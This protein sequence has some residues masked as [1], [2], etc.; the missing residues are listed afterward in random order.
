MVKSIWQ[1]PQKTFA[2]IFLTISSSMMIL[3]SSESRE[4]QLANEGRI[5]ME[6][7]ILRKI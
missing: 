6:L 7:K 5:I 2:R 1:I 3:R 4:T